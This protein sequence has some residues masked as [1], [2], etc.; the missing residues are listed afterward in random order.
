M[1]LLILGGCGDMG[2]MAVAT[3]I[4]L[5]K[6]SKITIADKNY[7]LAERMVELTESEKLEAVKIDINNETELIKLV[8]KHDI[9][10]NTVGPFYKFGVPILNAVI[11]GKTNYVDICDD[12]K[13]TQDML[14]LNKKAKEAG[15]SCIIGVGASP[16]LTNLMA[17]MAYKELD[18]V[19]DI[20][21]AWGLGD[22]KLGKKPKNFIRK[23][24]LIKNIKN[25]IRNPSAAIVHL[26]YQSIGKKPTYKNG[27]L[28]EIESLTS[29]D[30]IK[31][32]GRGKPI[33]SCHIGH[34]EPI[35]LSRT[36][37]ANNISNQM[38]LTKKL[39][40][41]LGDYVDKIK[42]NQITINEAAI[43]IKKKLK[44]FKVILTI[45]WIVI[46][47]L[48][49]LPPTL[50]VIAKGLKDE[51]ETEIYVGLKYQ[52][53]GEI[54]RGTDGITAVPMVIAASMLMDGLISKTG[55]LTPEEAID[56]DKFFERFA[57]FCN[58]NL[59]KEDVLIK[60]IISI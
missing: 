22:T 35:T 10:L 52:P 37:K 48:F 19:Y 41:I 6:V 26:L 11:K 18:Q 12:W 25:K 39:T 36:I 23:K 55:V 38:Y 2:R 46:K 51:K 14:K 15:I 24:N 7:E 34:P 29:A 42:T 60:K 5:P 44:S 8:R 9:V 43:S 59:K 33:Y 16:G 53:F 56:P 17:V 57:D 4:S 13:P 3:A 58:L 28:K 27:D 45:I 20:I 30:P 31:F 1:K 50:C 49:K 21:T 40:M 32:P 47:R 54:D